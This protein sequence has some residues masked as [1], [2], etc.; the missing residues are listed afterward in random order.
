MEILGG[1]FAELR[2]T[3]LTLNQ[4]DLPGFIQHTVREG[5]ARHATDY[6][7]G[8]QEVK[9]HTEEVAGGVRDVMKWWVQLR[10]CVTAQEGNLKEWMSEA[11]RRWQQIPPHATEQM[12]QMLYERLANL[13]ATLQ[14]PLSEMS[15]WK[16]HPKPR[17]AGL[18]V[19]PLT[20]EVEES[21]AQRT[22]IPE[23]PHR[24]SP[25]GTASV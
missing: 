7:Q 14:P 19:H 6:W 16:T 13:E 20:E 10:D 15:R 4:I 2:N 22:G 5:I 17:A 3:H 11:E 12:A 18:P 21:P 25:E 23:T 9:Q 24:I 1:E 8:L